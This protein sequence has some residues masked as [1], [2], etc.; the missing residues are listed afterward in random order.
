[1]SGLPQGFITFASALSATALNALWEDALLVVCIALLLRLWPRINAATR[2]TVWGATLVAAFALPLATTLAFFATPHADVAQHRYVASVHTAA[3]MPAA[4]TGLPRSNVLQRAAAPPAVAPQRERIRFTL[5]VPLAIAVFVAWLLLVVYAL[6]R[7]T[8]GLMRLEQ[9]KRDALPLPVEYRE[10]MPQWTRASKGARDVRLC[11]SDD[12]DVPVAVGLFDSVILVPHTLLDGL[13]QNE[14]DQICLHE[15]AHLRRGDDWSNGV[16]RVLIALLGW[17]P[18][19]QFIG[20]QLDLER[21]V[22]CDD[23]VLS[24]GGMVRPYA[25]CLTKMAERAAWPRHPIPAPGVFATRK[26][27]SLRIERLLGAGRNIAT[28]LSLAPAAAAVAVVG[29]IALLTTAVAPS[30]AASS[31]VSPSVPTASATVPS[32]EKPAAEKTREIV[33]Y[34]RV[35]V[36]PNPGAAATATPSATVPRVVHVPGTHVHVPAHTVRLPEINVDVPEQTI[37]IP[38]VPNIDATRIKNEVNSEVRKSLSSALAAA[39][40]GRLAQ[41][42]PNGRNCSGCEFGAVNWSGRDMR[43]VNYSGVDLSNATLN[44]TNFSD[45]KFNGVDFTYAN[46]RNASFRGAQMTGCDFSHADLTGTDFTGSRLSGCQFTGAR[47]G[48]SQLRDVLNSCTGCDFS[49][50]DLRGLN[51]SNVRANGDDF[52]GAD[53]RD[54]NFAGAELAGIDFSDARLDGANLTGTVF[55][56]SDLGGVD[57]SR[58]DVSRAKFIGT[59]SSKKRSPPEPQG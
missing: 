35:A 54:V 6:V 40:M 39:K 31:V 56:G 17:N 43:G 25:L 10:S 19:A 46:L 37:P 13:S 23:W 15:L 36:A 53:L 11:I 55:N 12:T 29:A 52:T 42:S 7:L 3:R 41:N 45:G 30:V 22:A 5:P 57:M 44:G 1:M 38:S 16:Q 21:E 48:S 59:Y 4:Q 8:I 24:L 26:H 49:K 32:P 14:V 28:N 2:Y 20:Q 18:A 51:L 33:R 9:L 34:V 58:V 47:L 27:I 50:A